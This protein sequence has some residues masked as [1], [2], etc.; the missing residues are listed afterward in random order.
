MSPPT[1]NA[2]PQRRKRNSDIFPPQLADV[3]RA[4]HA[5]QPL[6]F[7]GCGPPGRDVTRQLQVAGYACFG[8]YWH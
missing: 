2:R 1:A 7:M 4:H 3:R 5:A 8:F 6:V